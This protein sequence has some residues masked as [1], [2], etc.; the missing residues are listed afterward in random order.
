M[1]P[2]T[3][4]QKK[5]KT[6]FRAPEILQ[7]IRSNPD[8]TNNVAGPKTKFGAPKHENLNE[9]PKRELN[10]NKCSMTQTMHCQILSESMW[11]KNETQ[12]LDPFAESSR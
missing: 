6:M 8:K 2:V 7:G 9:A 11:K 1:K 5:T 3:E 12:N 10:G 4:N